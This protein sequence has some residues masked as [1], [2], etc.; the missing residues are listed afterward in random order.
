M[1]KTLLTL[2]LST[3]LLAAPA[4]FAQNVD[5]ACVVK[6]ADGTETVDKAK[7]PD[8]KTPA[9]QQKSDSNSQAPAGN[10]ATTQQKSDSN[11]QVPA[12]NNAANTTAQ[13]APGDTTGSITLAPEVLKSGSKIFSA[14]DFIGKRVY[15]TANEDIG[16]VNDVILSEDGKVRAV[17]LGV[18][19]FLGIGEKD[20]A[21][22]M[23]SIQMVQDGNSMKLAI[24]TTKD[25]LKAAPSY[26]RT[27]RTYVQ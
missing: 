17:I 12:D 3:T 15:S 4:A 2:A 1:Q 20:V 11:T 26:D 10:D 6:N 9:A 24:N 25:M 18:G 22:D 16:E 19:G 5:P 27:T 7:C 14:N 8:G 21:V 13:P 23:N